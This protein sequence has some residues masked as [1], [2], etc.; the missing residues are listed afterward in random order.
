M[1]SEKII[2]SIGHSTHTIDEF[3]HL[4]QIYEIKAIA[5]VRRFP[6]SKKYPHFERQNLQQEFLRSNIDYFWLGELLGGYRKG[7]YHAYM[8][9]EP[10]LEG[11]KQLITLAEKQTAAI[12]CA[13]RLFFRCHRRFIS[14]QLLQMEWNVV[15]IVDEKRTYPHKPTDTIPLNPLD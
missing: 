15:H 4:L 10:F 13:E 9:S 2:Y 11:M 8:Q 12:M 14:D 7:G 6:T 5:D 1:N 3:L